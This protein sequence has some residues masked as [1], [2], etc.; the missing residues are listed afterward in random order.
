MDIVSSPYC[1]LY[2][3]NKLTALHGWVWS[4]SFIDATVESP[5]N[6]PEIPNICFEALNVYIIC[7][8]LI[9]ITFINIERLPVLNYWEHE[10]INHM[11]F[12]KV[13]SIAEILFFTSSAMMVAISYSFSWKR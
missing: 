4:N 5:F 8:F 3:S 10:T 12:F 13:W 1:T 11:F 7:T 2:Y 9:A 6:T